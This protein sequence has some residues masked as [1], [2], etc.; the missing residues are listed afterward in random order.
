[1]PRQPQPHP[2]FAPAKKQIILGLVVIFAIYFCNTYF[3]Q[4]FTVARPRMAA[5]LNGM[6]LYAWSI[7]IPSLAAAFVTLLFAR[8]MYI[9]S[10]GLLTAVLAGIVF[11]S[12]ETPLSM[13][14]PAATL[15]GLSLGA[16]PTV[17]TLVVQY[18][19]PKRLLGVSLG[20]IL[21]SITMG[22]AIA[23]A[24]L[25]SV[26]NVSY[27]AKLGATLPEELHRFADAGTMTARRSEGAFISE[28]NDRSRSHVR[29]N[30]RR[31][32]TAFQKDG[33]SHPHLDG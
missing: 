1:M 7:S 10:Y 12:P 18:V 28:A 3:I 21:F 15:A 8:W 23:P 24:V 11:F 25:G 26:M 29:R 27:A 5:D 33:G 16:I 20:A 30:G 13:E 4:T 17:N 2:E 31:R 9:F 32:E 19:V 6:A 22:M 14:L